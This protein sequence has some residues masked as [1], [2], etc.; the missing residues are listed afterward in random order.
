M[1]LEVVGLEW[2]DAAG[3]RENA[4]AYVIP[5]GEAGRRFCHA[6]NHHRHRE[7]APPP[8]PLTSHPP[9]S[10]THILVHAGM[11][12][13]PQRVA[14][15]ASVRDRERRRGGSLRPSGTVAPLAAQGRQPAGPRAQAGH[16]GQ[17]PAAQPQPPQATRFP[18]KAATI[19]EG[20][21]TILTPRGTGAKEELGEFRRGP[22][23]ARKKK[24]RGEQRPN[25]VAGAWAGVWSLEALRRTRHTA[26]HGGRSRAWAAWT[27]HRTQMRSNRESERPSSSR[28]TQ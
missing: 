26:A 23:T 2:T 3:P 14:A 4:P 19:R 8:P 9:H 1:F 21:P 16:R 13:R 20:K 12:E 6:T 15:R 7:S 11:W 18:G 28:S 10:D 27:G 22:C 17:A 24:C 25:W 5:L